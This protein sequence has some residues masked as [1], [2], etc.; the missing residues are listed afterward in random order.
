FSPIQKANFFVRDRATCC[1]SGANLWLLDA[2]L[3]P[4]YQRDWADHV[5]PS[6]RRGA[7]DESN[8]VCASH[9]FNAKKRHNSADTAYLFRD[10]RPTQLYL[11]IFGTVSAYQSER[12]AR[13]SRL[14]IADWYFNRAIGQIFLSF[15]YRFDR[16]VYEQ[17]PDRDTHHWLGAALKC[18]KNFRRLAEE[19]KSRESRG[20]VRKPD[21]FQLRWLYLRTV[22][23]EHELTRLIAP[24]YEVYYSNALAWNKYFWDP[25]VCEPQLSE[26]RRL[27]AVR[28]AERRTDLTHDTLGCILDDYERRQKKC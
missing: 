8:G 7:S 9:T 28:F 12:L 15:D 4:G 18:L 20:V 22:E 6:A 14:T 10:G 23:T 3:R 11:E 27:S 17:Y 19:E 1:F 13:L 26:R 5:K 2:P 25:E 16:D 24:L 21:K